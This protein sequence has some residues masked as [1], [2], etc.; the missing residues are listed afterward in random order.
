[1]R[2]LLKII[3]FCSLSDFTV[4]VRKPSVGV[5]LSQLTINEK[6]A[7]SGSRKQKPDAFVIKIDGHNFGRTFS[8]FNDTERAFTFQ[9]ETQL[10]SHAKNY[11]H[12][13]FQKNNIGKIKLQ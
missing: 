3:L 7:A 1:M 4:V 8:L 11:C 10:V 12:L 5:T 9:G 6:I 13:C 2:S